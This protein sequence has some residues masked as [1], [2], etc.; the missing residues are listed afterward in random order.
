MGQPGHQ[1]RANCEVR[2]SWLV[3]LLGLRIMREQSAL[4]VMSSEDE[5][6][7]FS[8]D[9]EGEHNV[10]SFFLEVVEQS[11]SGMLVASYLEDEERARRALSH[12]SMDHLCQEMLDAWQSE[13]WRRVG[14]DVLRRLSF[15][16]AP[17]SLFC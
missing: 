7:F 15:T 14:N 6:D 12:P 17:F 3:L 1:Q 2:G 4:G 5:D 10:S 16:S 11:R 9:E 13:D 8:S